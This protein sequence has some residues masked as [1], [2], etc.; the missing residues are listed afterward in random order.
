MKK[1][2]LPKFS[3]IFFIISGVL[4]FTYFLLSV[5]EKLNIYIYWAGTSTQEIL[6]SAKIL[7]F[8]P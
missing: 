7:P 6:P 2:T 1:I 3:K 8:V 4:L 5:L